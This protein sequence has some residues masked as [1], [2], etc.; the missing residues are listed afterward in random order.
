[1]QSC[2]VIHVLYLLVFFASLA[3]AVPVAE[4]ISP[5]EM[6]EMLDYRKTLMFLQHFLSKAQHNPTG[7]SSPLRKRTCYFN[8]GM[9]HNCDYK[10]L[11]GAV[12]EANYW[13]SELTPGRRRRRSLAPAIQRN[14]GNLQE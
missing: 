14:T 9:S 2:S 5:N 10:E 4:E 11:V 12:D 7:N 6:Q 8:A 3:K 1:M 13:S